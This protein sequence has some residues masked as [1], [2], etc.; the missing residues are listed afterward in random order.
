MGFIPELHNETEKAIVRARDV[1]ISSAEG[2][3]EQL[4]FISD[5]IL[6]L[7][8]D[9][10]FSFVDNDNIRKSVLRKLRGMKEYLENTLPTV[11]KAND[12]SFLHDT[13]L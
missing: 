13:S 1:D 12:C 7:Q 5:L 8:G 2:L 6:K 9:N 3:Q 11:L 4:L 10:T